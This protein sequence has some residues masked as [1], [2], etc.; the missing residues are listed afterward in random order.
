MANI[1]SFCVF[2]FSMLKQV[3]LNSTRTKWKHNKSA[4]EKAAATR[5]NGKFYDQSESST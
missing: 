1:L 3:N 4:I 2:F 5:G